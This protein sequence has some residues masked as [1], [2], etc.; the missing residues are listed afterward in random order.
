M[1]FFESFEIRKKKYIQQNQKCFFCK[2]ELNFMLSQLAHVVPQTKKNIKKYGE[3]KIHHE[4]NM[5]L[6]CSQ[7]CNSKVM[8]RPDSIIEKNIMNS[9]KLN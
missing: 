4:N 3:N 6:V 8:C 9:I 5:R 7:N 2:K 1:C